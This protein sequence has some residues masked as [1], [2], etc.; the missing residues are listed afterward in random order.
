MAG[1]GFE[2]KKLFRARTA[3]GH[4]RAYTYSA[5]ITAGPFAFMTCM[6]L[7]IQVLLYQ[8]A[9]T[10]AEAGIFMGAVV[11]SFVFSQIFSSGFTMVVTRY[12]AD[13][14][15]VGRY[16]DITASL[17]GLLTLLTVAGGVV[18]A[19]FLWPGLLPPFTKLLMY[20]FFLLLMM[21]WGESIYLSAIK[22]YKRLLVSY[23]W[24]CLVS[25]LL[26]WGLLAADGT[27]LGLSA[28][29]CSLLA[30]CLG[31]GLVDLLF[32][33]HITTYFGWPSGGLNF[34]FLPYFERHWRLFLVAFFYMAGL[35]APNIIIW[36]GPD[37][38]SVAG[39]FRFSP[40]Y[41]VLT[42]YAFLSILPLMMLF[43]VSME[44]RFYEHY[45]KYFTLITHAGNFRQ[46]D[47][48]RKDMVQILWF[49]L[50][51]IVEF[52]FVFTLVA[53]VLGNYI[54]TGMNMPYAD[55]NLFDV[56]LTAAF[57][58]GLLQLLYVLMIYFDCQKETLRLS[59]F[60]FISNLALG[61]IGLWLGRDSYGFTFFLTSAGSFLLGLW[62]LDHYLKR[63][64][65]YVFCSQPVFVRQVRGPLF[66][67]VRRLYGERYVELDAL[68]EQGSDS[69]TNDMG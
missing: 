32:L 4:I 47:D 51:H 67:L 58:I 19:V 30:L 59:A 8:Y 36:Q 10:D 6:I 69:G 68:K 24:G 61:V 27:S 28:S 21:A 35:F 55:V 56:L 45:A 2:L 46:I 34:A 12:L 33:L 57:F 23:L 53:F 64:N 1:V 41:D 65:Y 22:H 39:I 31:I 63:V 40:R 11:Y 43:V 42:F 60:F 25:I 14:I 50:R 37:G 16:A 17:F 18:A 44:T 48:A 66:W 29:Q 38:I 52:Q 13:S 20:L 62:R 15:A 54:F 7:A 26:T 5:L 3:V 9:V 49:E